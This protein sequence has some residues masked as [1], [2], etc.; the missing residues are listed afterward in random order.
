M[1][2]DETTIAVANL[3]PRSSKTHGSP[4]N[5]A[6]KSLRRKWVC[7]GFL[8]NND[9]AGRTFY[10][11][12][13]VKSNSLCS[14]V[15]INLNLWN[16][17]AFALDR[18]SEWLDQIEENLS[19]CSVWSRRDSSSKNSSSQFYLAIAMRTI[20]DWVVKHQ[21][22]SMLIAVASAGSDSSNSNAWP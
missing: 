3:G 4:W 11:S 2:K 6:T 14:G 16:N 18:P 1:K 12:L 8:L 21:D 17:S 22:R 10:F 5:D 7:F 19:D 20:A 9:V 15:S 13:P